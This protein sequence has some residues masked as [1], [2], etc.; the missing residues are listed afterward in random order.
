MKWFQ[1]TIKMSTI[2]NID[3]KGEGVWE[4]IHLKVIPTIILTLILMKKK[5]IL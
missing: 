2:V 4:R 1:K 3:Y 5:E